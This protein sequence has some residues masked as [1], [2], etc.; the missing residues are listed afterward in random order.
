MVEVE[1]REEP[2]GDDPILDAV[3]F[4][5][6]VGRRAWGPPPLVPPLPVKFTEWFSGATSGDDLPA[7]PL[8]VLGMTASQLS[9]LP[10]VVR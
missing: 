9:R 6:R 10:G 2:D 7:C 8:Y 1:V 5:A 4:A 3:Q